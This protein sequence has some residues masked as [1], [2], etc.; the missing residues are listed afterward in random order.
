MITLAK[1]DKGQ[2]TQGCIKTTL[3]LDWKS[4]VADNVS[5]GDGGCSCKIGLFPSI[6]AKPK[7]PR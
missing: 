5:D 6:V 3:S 7:E 1:N 4:F 2:F